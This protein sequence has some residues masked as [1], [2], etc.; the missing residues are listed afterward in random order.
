MS[1][2]GCA[3][4]GR[5]GGSP[6]AAAG[7]TGKAPGPREPESPRPWRAACGSSS[8][9]EHC[10]Q[11]VEQVDAGVD[12]VAIDRHALDIDAERNLARVRLVEDAPQV[13]AADVDRF[14]ERIGGAEDRA[15]GVGGDIDAE[16]AQEGE[17]L[18]APA[19]REGEHDTPRLAARA[20][21]VAQVIA[22]QPLRR[23]RGIDGLRD[24]VA[25]ALD[26]LG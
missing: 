10:A 20:A 6:A 9:G 7:E 16:P 18:L 13:V 8:A 23:P 21:A 26:A 15:L 2:P 11:R 24:E 14:G 12:L 3:R 22:Q 5:A 25:A 1:P 17:R 19:G 4:S